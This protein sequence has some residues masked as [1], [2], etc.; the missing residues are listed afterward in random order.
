MLKKIDQVRNEVYF[1][2]EVEVGFGREGSGEVGENEDALLF[3][4]KV[5]RAKEI[6]ESVDDVGVI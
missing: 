6:F 3:H 5:F 4:S 2:D 1:F